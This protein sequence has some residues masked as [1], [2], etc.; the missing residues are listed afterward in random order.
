M[1][2]TAPSPAGTL[3]IRLDR[4]FVPDN[5]REL[6]EEHLSILQTSIAVRGRIVVPV[7]V[8]DADPGVHGDAYDY[9]LVAG[10]HRTEAAKRLGHDTIPATYGDTEHEAGDRALE[11]VTRKQLN[12]YEEAVAVKAMIDRGYSEEGAAHLLGWDRRRVTARVKLLK[13]PDRA[14]KMVGEGQITLAAVD[15]MRTIQQASPALLELAIDYVEHHADRFEADQLARRPLWLLE[16]AMYDADTDAFIGSLNQV[17]I[18]SLVRNEDVQLGAET[19]ALLAEALEIAKKLDRWAYG[20]PSMRFTDAEVDR[21]R[22]AG[23]LLEYGNEDPL[24]TDFELYIDLCRSAIAAGVAALRQQLA[25]KGAAKTTKAKAAKASD[26][27]AELQKAHRREMR[28]IAATAHTANLDLGDSLRNGL[29]TVD[30]ADM[31]V[32]RFFVYGLLGSDAT[33]I[34]YA[35][36]AVAAIA[37]R[38]IRLVLAEFRQDVTKTKKDGSRGTLRITYG[39]GMSHE[40]QAHW[41]WTHLQGAT[42]AGEL[43]GRALVVIAA[44]HY[45]SRLVVPGS[46]QRPPLQWSSHNNLAIKALEKLAGPHVAPTL[47]AL[48]KAVAKAKREHDEATQALAAAHRDARIAQAASDRASSAAADDDQDLDDEDFTYDDQEPDPDL[49]YDDD[50]AYYGEDGHTSAAGDDGDDT[51]AA[52]TLVPAATIAPAQATAASTVPQAASAPVAAGLP[53]AADTAD[54]AVP[55]A[56]TEPELVVDASAEID[57]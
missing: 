20:Y 54:P 4:L 22:A 53:P 3:T 25:E 56:T 50:P 57:F 41:L 45:A 10:F 14:Q 21:A 11:N 43:Y 38:G 30:P 17:P 5:V 28:A 47:K 48:E 31:D 49:V 6:D 55:E 2:A 8:I 35:D 24:V 15:A 16:R 34:Y 51:P 29:S 42:T 46:Q 7:Q 36:T 23:A 26:P 27:V 44:E 9:V 1:S 12:P 40:N 39:D 33:S 13:L 52:V 19:D 37:L 18:S 32:A